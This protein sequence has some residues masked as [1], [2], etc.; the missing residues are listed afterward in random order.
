MDE[1]LKALQQALDRSLSELIPS[2][3]EPTGL[4]DPMRYI[5]GIGGKR[6]RPLLTL[7][8]LKAAGKDPQL[9]WSA[10]M[11]IEVFHNFSLVH[12]D[13]MD[14]APLRRGK[15]TVHEK[16]DVNTGILSGDALLVKAYQLMADVPKDKVA[17]I[18]EVFSETALQVCEGQ[19]WDVEFE[20]RESVRE[21]DYIRMIQYKTSVLLGC[22]LKVG[23]ILSDLPENHQKALY[24]FGLEM[25]TS[26]QIA[27]DLLDAFGDPEK[28]GKKVGGDILENKKT[29]LFIAAE[30]LGSD[31]QK[32]SLRQWYSING[33]VS[34]KV[35]AVKEI[36]ESTGAR[37]YVE[38]QKRSY[39][40]SAISNL[41]SLD[42]VLVATDLFEDFARY[43]YERDH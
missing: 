25:G 3:A 26:F 32:R 8:V 27:D 1:R 38:D 30:R 13:I 9:G 43:L 2:T 14:A 20:Q 12:D 34:G 15:E 21:E 35:D 33:D 39:Y 11:G 37:R 31:D 17:P 16:W 24:S 18:L 22:A 4:Y 7:M 10:A 36:F 28:F 42:N 6:L 5:L 40:E 19:Q 23:A 41:T 29:L